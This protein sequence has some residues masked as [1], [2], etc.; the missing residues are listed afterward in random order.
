MNRE[1]LIHQLAGLYQSSFA[2]VKSC[3]L[4]SSVS[5]IGNAIAK[6]VEKVN[7]EFSTVN[8]LADD[9]PL[10]LQA[11]VTAR[12]MVLKDEIM[13]HMPVQESRDVLHER[14]TT[15]YIES[16]NAFTE[17]G[18][19]GFYDMACTITVMFDNDVEKVMSAFEAL[20]QKG[21][22]QIFDLIRKDNPE[23]SRYTY[24]AK[25]AIVFPSSLISQFDD[26]LMPF[27]DKSAMFETDKQ[28]KYK[29]YFISP[30]LNDF[31]DIYSDPIGRIKGIL[32][33][34]RLSTDGSW[35]VEDA[36]TALG[37]ARFEFYTHDTVAD[38]VSLSLALVA[39]YGKSGSEHVNGV[40][41]TSYC[42]TDE[43]EKYGLSTRG[44]RDVSVSG[45]NKGVNMLDELKI[46]AIRCNDELKKA[47]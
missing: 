37:C 24:S 14:L 38:K 8:S 33:E 25:I 11:D 22:V 18:G 35:S 36:F 41:Q 6:A 43:I 27:I 4:G 21:D 29:K 46:Y 2:E 16:V 5:G 26:A 23:H 13:S 44:F 39:L 31:D 9:M 12:L 10:G 47:G 42:Y 28:V 3:H 20:E 45:P 19:T 15:E 17:A 30:L 40:M 7:D 32:A 1:T 34:D